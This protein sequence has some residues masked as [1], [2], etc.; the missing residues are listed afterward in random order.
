MHLPKLF[1]RKTH[2]RITSPSTS[3]ERIHGIVQ[4]SIQSLDDD[5]DASSQKQSIANAPIHGIVQSSLQDPDPD[6]NPDPGSDS[7][8]KVNI[9]ADI[10]ADNEDWQKHIRCTMMSKSPFPARKKG[11]IKNNPIHDIVQIIVHCDT[12]SLKKD[13]DDDDDDDEEDD[14]SEEDWVMLEKRGEEAK[15]IRVDTYQLHRHRHY[16]QHQ[17]HHHHHQHEHEH[18]H[19]HNHHDYHHNPSC[20]LPPGFTTRKPLA[21]NTNTIGAFSATTISNL[22]SLLSRAE[23]SQTLSYKSA[24]QVRL[25]REAS[26]SRDRVVYL[27]RGVLY[28]DVAGGDEGGWVGRGC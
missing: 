19:N 21:P 5:D 28:E 8:P 25:A 26:R 16:H 2:R 18:T 15:R 3:Q 23:E 1:H 27:L 22:Q 7:D 6:P 10:K 11:S 14:D 20:P 12:D 9:K 13:D 24:S 17:H 4:S